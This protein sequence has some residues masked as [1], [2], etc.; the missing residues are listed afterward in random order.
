MA[1]PEEGEIAA[2]VAR[3]N[4]KIALLVRKGVKLDDLNSTSVLLLAA[5]IEKLSVDQDWG[6]RLISEMLPDREPE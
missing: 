1:I 4:G 6:N 3:D 5:V 2:L